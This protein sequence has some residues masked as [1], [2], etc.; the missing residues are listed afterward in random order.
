MYQEGWRERGTDVDV[1][2]VRGVKGVG[3][4][5]WGKGWKGR[6]EEPEG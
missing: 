6:M 5:W 4:D 3:A 2:R 1:K